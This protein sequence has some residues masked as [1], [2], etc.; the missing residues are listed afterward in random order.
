MVVG[1]VEGSEEHA[2]GVR[3][4][5]YGADNKLV[6]DEPMWLRTNLIWPLRLREFPGGRIEIYAE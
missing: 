2:S 6:S 4:A 1:S 5:I 3:I